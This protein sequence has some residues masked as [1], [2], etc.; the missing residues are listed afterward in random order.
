[1]K[2]VDNDACVNGEAP[3][4]VKKGCPKQAIRA[5]ATTHGKDVNESPVGDD[6]SATPDKNRSKL[7]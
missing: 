4:T 6:G 1:M 3:W 2:A 7:Y 5:A